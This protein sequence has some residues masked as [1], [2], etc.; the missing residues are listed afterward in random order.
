[1]RRQVKSNTLRGNNLFQN[2]SQE[3]ETTILASSTK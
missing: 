3:E 1:M 2:L